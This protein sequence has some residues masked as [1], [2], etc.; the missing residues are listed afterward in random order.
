MNS[1]RRFVPLMS[2][3][4]HHPDDARH[5][6]GGRGV[7]AA[8]ERVPVG[9]A[10]HRELQ[11]AGHPDV[12]AEAG[13]ARRL[14]HGAGPGEGRAEHR[15]VRGGQQVRGRDL[16]ADEA[17]GQL[18]RVDDLHV[19]GAAAQV[20]SQRPLHL[21]PRGIRVGG[22]ELL[23]RHDH[24]RDAEAAL[25]GAG[26]DERLL[27]EVRPVRRAQALDRRDLR[28][29]ERRDLG[30]A[31]EHGL[32]VDEDHAR[33]ALALAVAGLLR[34]GEAQVLADDVQQDRLL[35][36]GDD[37][38]GTSVDGETDLVHETLVLRAPRVPDNLCRDAR[39]LTMLRRI[40]RS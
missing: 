37:L 14:R 27:D 1:L 40:G 21:C 31:R 3:R 5:R 23:G 15:R 16:A 22:E 18:D 36:V 7:D 13:R 6:L 11:R 20:A 38:H 35:P 19:A 2:L 32:A 34:P 10:G 4:G 26:Q 8:D 28:A 24:A 29:V 39:T 17:A 33:A 30:D 9:A 25:D 12:R